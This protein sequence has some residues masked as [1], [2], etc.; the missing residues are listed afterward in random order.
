M[1]Y[2]VGDR[3]KVINPVRMTFHKGTI[4][5]STHKLIEVKIDY[6]VGYFYFPE[7]ELQLIKPKTKK[8]KK[9]KYTRKSIWWILEDYKE[10]KNITP[11]EYA[12]IQQVQ[13]DL[14]AQKEDRKECKHIPDREVGLN[15][16]SCKKCRCCFVHKSTP[17][18]L[19][20]EEIETLKHRFM[21][22]KNHCWREL[23]LQDQ[24][25]NSLIRNQKKL[26]QFIKEKL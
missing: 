18:P 3:V 26:Y 19:E 23:S 6:Y 17:S 14:L 2:K 4:T 20:I 7:S 1:K 12:R 10:A 9:Y 11:S 25:I 13:K 16:W 5:D 22:G 24:K 15:V 21:S 8:V